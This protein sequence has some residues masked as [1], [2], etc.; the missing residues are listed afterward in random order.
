MKLPKHY[1]SWTTVIGGAIAMISLFMIIILF[2][3]SLVFNESDNY[4]G[5]FTFIILPMI[6]FIGL[7]I[8]FVGMISRVRKKRRQQ[9]ITEVKFPIVDFNDPKQRFV[10]FMFGIGLSV[11]VVLS[12]LGGYQAFHY[13]ES[14]KFCGTLC[15]SVMEPEYTAYQGSAHAR[16]N[17][18]ECHVGSGAG[19][20]VRSKLSGLY[21]VY[22][23]MANAYPTPIP[24]PLHNLRP[25]QETCEK[26]H[27]P[28]KFYDRKYISHKHYLAEE[29]NTEWDI[30][31]VMKTG[32]AYRALGQIEGIHWHINANV[33][34]EYAATSL[35]R[36]TIVL[37]KYTNLKT[38][39]VMVY[40]NEKNPL[41]EAQIAGL[42]FR[43]MDCLDCHN[44]PS[45]DYKSPA[46][47][48]DAAMT[49]GKISKDLP[50]IKTAAMDILRNDFPT[51][52]SA[53]SYI[54]TEI[55]GYYELMYPDLLESDRETID[56]AIAAIKEGYAKNTFPMMKVKWNAYPNYLGHL[57]ND[58]CYR[59]HNDAFKNQKNK[60]ISRDCTLCHL[61]KEQGRPGEMEFATGQGFL[62]FKHPVDIKEKWKT[63]HCA[64]CHFE[65]Y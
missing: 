52:D 44:R 29:E 31:M 34:I 5:L 19:W 1:Y 38:G 49:A 21:Q 24:T 45:H 58:G 12:A 64:E 30:G 51:L 50:D 22:S 14:N 36:D 25:A 20:Y 26:C 61:I 13:T 46:R 11:F 6:M 65:L 27:W 56:A 59:C 32:P 8:M 63:K 17:C 2:L 40:N 37:V 7:G 62:E 3:I 53:Y 23:V 18:V 16:V 28:E 42:E 54:E 33:K 10:V 9:D 47:Y 55:L 41:S 4:S 60:V 15:H 48:F 39:E 57:E 43:T 35:K